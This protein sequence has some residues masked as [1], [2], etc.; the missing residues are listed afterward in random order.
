MKGPVPPV[1]VTFAV[2]LQALGHEGFVEVMLRVMGGFTVKLKVLI[3][4]YVSP[5]FM[6]LL[7]SISQ[8]AYALTVWTIGDDVLL[9]PF[10]SVLFGDV[11]PATGKTL[12]YTTQVGLDAAT[13]FCQV[14][15]AEML[16]PEQMVD[17]A[18]LTVVGEQQ[19][20]AALVG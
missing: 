18:L 1:T 4:V 14:V 6:E 5:V 11:V 20:N 7:P 15:I 13:A 16:S 9:M 19:E 10:G 8:Y 3:R 17:D 2:P 12:E